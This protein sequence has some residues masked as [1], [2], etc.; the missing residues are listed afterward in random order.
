MAAPTSACQSGLALRRRYDRCCTRPAAVTASGGAAGSRIVR[1]AATSS[2]ASVPLS[3]VG[4]VVVDAGMV[5]GTGPVEVAVV[6]PPPAAAPV[7][8]TVAVEAGPVAPP[9]PLHA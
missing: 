3:P 7:A 2:A 8:P 4:R 5:A 1:S 6:A 9:P